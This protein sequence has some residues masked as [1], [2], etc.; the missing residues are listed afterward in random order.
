M[1]APYTRCVCFILL[2]GMSS[3]CF[4]QISNQS[5][6]TEPVDTTQTIRL[7]GSLH[8]LAKSA[9]DRE[10]LNGNT[11][12]HGVSLIFKHSEAQQNELR[13]L[14]AEQQDPSSSRY[15]KWLT[16]EQFADRFGLT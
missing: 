11:T 14:L 6:I 7:A 1:S 8:P 15:R 5:R 16:P 4:A 9:S 2:Q 3:L 12:L 10:R 13:K